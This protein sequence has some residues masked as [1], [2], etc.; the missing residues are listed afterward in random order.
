MKLY[1]IVSSERARKGQGGNDHL[2]IVVRDADQQVIAHLNFYPNNTC[3]MSILKDIKV[4]YDKPI[5]IGTD[6][7]SKE[8]KGKKQKTA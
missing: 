1:A 4:D 3:R 8:I 5:W 7:D 6:D 2:N